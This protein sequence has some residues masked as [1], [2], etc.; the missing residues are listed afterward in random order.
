MLRLAVE[1]PLAPA[2]NR[3]PTRFTGW[4]FGA[5]DFTVREELI[6]QQSTAVGNRI[7]P[8]L[9]AIFDKLL[10]AF[11]AQGRPNALPST[12]G[13]R[14]AQTESVTA[15]TQQIFTADTQQ[16]AATTAALTCRAPLQDLRGKLTTSETLE[17]T[18]EVYK[19]LGPLW[20]CLPVED[21]PRVAHDA[22][23]NSDGADWLDSWPL[24]PELRKTLT[25]DQSAIL[26]DWTRMAEDLVALQI[27]RWFAPALSHLLPMMQ[28]I[29]L[30]SIS[31]LLV[32]TSY[33]FDH[34]G[35]LT[36]VMVCLIVLV[37]TV[38]AMILIGVNRDELISRVANTA[39][40]RLTIDSNLTGSLL[41]MIAPL[42]A[43]LVAV[44]FDLSDLLHAWLG[45]LF[46]YF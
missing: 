12:A 4:F 31:L 34:Q 21:T 29:V 8:N 7:T 16:I 35:W 40:G 26:R 28:Y 2:Y 37:G 17:S 41:T 27:V 44:S 25:D 39:P 19:F 20:Q 42:V 32:V 14:P 15:E 13:R 38:V 43:A 6:R 1:L 3:I 5:A 46:Q 9:I 30:A 18:R 36:T 10:D 24:T 23:K 11:A 33:P 22:A 45:P